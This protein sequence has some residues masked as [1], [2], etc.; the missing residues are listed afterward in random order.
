MAEDI[1]SD[2]ELWS[3]GLFRL[4]RLEPLDLS[5]EYQ[6]RLDDNMRALKS[7]FFELQGYHRI[8]R[9]LEFSGAYRLTIRL[10]HTEY[11]LMAGAWMRQTLGEGRPSVRGESGF[12]LV[13]QVA[14][15]RDFNVRFTDDL[16]D[17]NSVR[18]VMTLTKP[19]SARVAP[20]FILGALGTWNEEYDFG[21]DKL[22]LGFGVRI[23]H[24]AKTRFRMMYIFEESRVTDPRERS[25]IIWIR[26]E[27]LAQ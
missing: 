12:D 2:W 27:I 16:I 4:N 22:R 9:W 24:T 14:Y 5:I 3:G 20:L 1:P 18:W 10:D 6:V 25:N 11:R 17:S 15:Q 7:H 21:L 19:L 8:K 23:N 26:Y 13:H